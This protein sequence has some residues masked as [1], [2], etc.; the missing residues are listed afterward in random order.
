[1]VL[2]VENELKLV[3]LTP[4][5]YEEFLQDCGDK[6]NGVSDMDWSEIIEK[7]NLPYDRRRISESMGRNILGGNFVREF[8]KNKTIGKSSDEVIKELVTKE[9]D[10]YKAKR[11]LQDERNELN[12]LLRNEARHEENLQIIEERI[13][14]IG[15]ERYP[16]SMNSVSYLY[17]S[18]AENQN[19]IIAC[20]S[21]L[22]FGLETSTYNIDVAKERLGK[23]IAEIKE[24]AEMNH[25]KKCVIMS[26]GDLISGS[27]H[28]GIQIANRENVVDQ[29]MTACELIADFVYK[30][31]AVFEKIEFYAVPGNHSRLEK[32]AD[33]SLLGERLDN[34][35]PWF[36]SHIF[37][38]QDKYYIGRDEA[39][40]TYT[41][42][43]IGNKNYL[44][45]H[46]DFDGISDA[47]VQKLCAY[48]GYFPYAIIMGH[49]HHPAMN[50]VSGVKVIQSGCLFDG[51]EYTERKRLRGTP[52]QTVIVCD[53]N[54]IKAIYPIEL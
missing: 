51:D 27:I 15:K 34:L 24:I 5:K 47:S 23:Y 8:Y 35:V 52:S 48:V 29:T 50:D 44:L 31:G 3:G 16:F 32:N 18:Y 9:Q 46:G 7:Y 42:V 1:M 36:L 11:K 19:T 22:H 43:P 21:D 30:L 14:K 4:E 25:A 12:K 28:L 2:N 38:H 49:M 6:I 37:A 41:E 40:T 10:I 20:L 26:C 54:R 39:K 45:V 53:N 17:S 13:E 33:D